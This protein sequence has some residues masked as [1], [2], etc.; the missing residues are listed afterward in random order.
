MVTVEAN[1]AK[2]AS[3]AIAKLADSKLPN[4]RLTTYS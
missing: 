2:A 4:A 1:K 3:I